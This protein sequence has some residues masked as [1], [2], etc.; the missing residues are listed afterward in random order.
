M[1]RNPARLTIFASAIALLAVAT[2]AGAWPFGAAKPAA[3]VDP[4]APHKATPEQ[5]AAAARLDPLSRA[6]FWQR[7]VGLDP[8]DTEASI[9]LSAALRAL[10]KYDEAA[11]TADRALL[12]APKNV[13]V[14]L[15]SARDH[16]AAGHGF[17][18]IQPLKDAET[19]APKDWR[20]RSLMG[21]ALEQSER[22]DEALIAYNDA[23]KLSPN[24][25]AALS[26]LALFYAT[27][28]D[29]AQAESLLRRAAADPRATSQ[30]RQNLALVLGLDGK[31]AEAERLMRQDLPPES[32]DA[33]LN[34]LKGGVSPHPTAPTAQPA[35]PAA[36][37][38]WGAVESSESK[39]G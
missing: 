21:V 15:E 24:N 20:P 8:A 7:E 32:A 2:P 26:N 36:A 35:A 39:G 29:T 6:T 34:Y 25:P 30:E 16:I 1:F 27:R 3:K 23:L 17:Y 33:N 4:N 18:A 10:G 12:A 9:G 11:D 19:L 22:P 28:G 14:L 38:T 13:E 5:R 37:H 31:T